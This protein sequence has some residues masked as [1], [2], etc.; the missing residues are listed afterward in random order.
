MPVRGQEG[1]KGNGREWGEGG[2]GGGGMHGGAKGGNEKKRQRVI[3]DLQCKRRPT[4]QG[5]TE[6]EESVGAVAWEQLHGNVGSD[7]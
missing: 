4:A 5:E 2:R 3:C 6:S 7:E 1:N